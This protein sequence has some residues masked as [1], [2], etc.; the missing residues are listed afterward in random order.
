MILNSLDD[1][2]TTH[3]GILA[4]AVILRDGGL[5]TLEIHLFL[6]FRRLWNYTVLAYGCEEHPITETT[7]LSTVTVIQ[8]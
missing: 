8:T 3:R 2:D 1:G 4:P 5:V 6:P 7:Q